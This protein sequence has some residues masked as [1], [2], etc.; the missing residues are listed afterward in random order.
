MRKIV[1]ITLALIGINQL[2]AQEREVTSNPY[3]F[4]EKERGWFW[5]EEDVKEEESE[6]EKPPQQFQ[7]AAPPPSA[8]TVALD[9]KWLKE[10]MPLL[11]EKMMD[12]PTEQNLANYAYAQRLMLDMASRLSTK[13]TDYMMG[14][15]LLDENNR[16]PTSTVSLN[17]FKSERA[18][19]VNQAIDEIKENTQG[20]WF[21]YAS[22]CPYCKKMIPILKRFKEVHK[23]E[24]LA[25]SLDGGIIEGME[26]FKIVV[27][28]DHTVAKRFNVTLTPTTYVVL[29]NNEPKLVAEGL[30][31][32]LDLKNRLLRTARINSVISE[33]TYQKT[34]SVFE[35]NMFDN[36][37]GTILVD[38][39]RLENDEDYLSQA[40]RKKMEEIQ[41][42]GT[43]V[44]Q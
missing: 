37:N 3:L 19:V 38:K 28:H 32:L 25:I 40:L 35:Q 6:P 22:N 17:S 27:D 20:L 26:D 34:R 15:T 44:V 21:F 41:P 31:D 13:M 16:R 42:F 10:N 36:K 8:E 23:M 24:I 9:S 43:R 12:N 1:L 2:N 33:D 30:K 7:P 14:E 18:D 11:M 4:K 39:N 5:F 29:N